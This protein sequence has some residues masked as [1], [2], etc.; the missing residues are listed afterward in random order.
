MR[1]NPQFFVDLVT[2]TDEILNGKLFFF[3]SVNENN[4]NDQTF[5]SNKNLQ[6][7]AVW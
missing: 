6:W 2:F 5:K 1:P 7:Q 4:Y 3:C